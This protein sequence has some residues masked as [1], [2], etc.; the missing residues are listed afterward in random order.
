MTLAG[1]RNRIGA[2][3]LAL[4][5]LLL[6]I[7][8]LVP[9]E[10]ALIHDTDPGSFESPE[11]LEQRGIEVIAYEN[12]SERGQEIYQNALTTSGT[13]RVSP[14]QGAPEFSYPTRADLASSG[15]ERAVS[16]LVA[17]E[18]PEDS[19]LPP[20]DEPRGRVRGEEGERSDQR[21]QQYELMET[22][23]GPPP[24]GSLSQL[25]RLLAGVL[26]VVSIGVG[27]YLFAS[28]DARGE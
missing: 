27:G 16:G 23:E 17:I 5:V 9:V 11:Q 22:R 21:A 10:P 19:N 1:R 8:V 14:G 13:H 18:R 12:L 26:G 4:G 24:L 6:V 15:D 28:L 20:A 7:P 25:L 3:L 2:G